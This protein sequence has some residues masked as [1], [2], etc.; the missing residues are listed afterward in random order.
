M[1]K[2]YYTCASTVTSQESSKNYDLEYRQ[3]CIKLHF[4]AHNDKSVGWAKIKQLQI[5]DPSKDEKLSNITLMEEVKP[6][7]IKKWEFELRDMTNLIDFIGIFGR[8]GLQRKDQ[9]PSFSFWNVL[10]K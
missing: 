10:L 1:I 8:S 5:K 2:I 7:L 3:S 6:A 4:L 9:D